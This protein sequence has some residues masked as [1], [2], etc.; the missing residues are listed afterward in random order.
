[1]VTFRTRNFT[2][3]MTWCSMHPRGWVL[4]PFN[5]GKWGVRGFW[6]VC[7][8]K[9][10]DMVLL[11]L[12]CILIMFPMDFQDV[13]QVLNGFSKMFRIALHF[14]PLQPLPKVVILDPILVGQ[15]S[16]FYI[17]TLWVKTFIPG[18]LQS[19]CFFWWWANQRGP[20]PRK[21]LNLGGTHN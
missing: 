9:V 7:L 14:Y 8:L 13:L 15:R 16:N 12:Q 19:F 1:M 17:S 20:S 3:P 21:N 5:L 18:S 6:I 4:L 10:F 2:K 11:S